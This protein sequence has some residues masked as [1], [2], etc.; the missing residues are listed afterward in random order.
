L[1]IRYKE[2]IQRNKRRYVSLLAGFFLFVAPFA[3]FIRLIYYFMGNIAEPTLHTVCLRMPIDWLF[4][5]RYYQLLGSVSAYFTLVVILMSFFL[6]PIFCGWLCPVGAVSEGI[7]RIIPLPKKYRIKIK[8]TNVTTGLRYGFLTGFVVV[9]AIAGRG[10]VQGIAGVCCR[11]CSSSILQNFSLALFG[12]FTALEYWHS[13]SLIVLVSWLLVGGIFSVGGRGWCM[14]FCPL[15]GFS[16][17]VHK[18]GAKL[19]LYRTEFNAEKCVNCEECQTF[20]P[21]W[22]IKEDKSVEKGLCINCQE[23]T[24]KCVGGAYNYQRG[25]E[26][27]KISR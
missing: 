16:N 11:Y 6:G 15:G 21:M 3:F 10:L 20:C 22:A 4:G 5:G 12:N 19:G 9:A 17:I 23:C 8:D 14:F 1:W 18:I 13:G 27:E 24:S 26:S 2:A 25:N 7:S